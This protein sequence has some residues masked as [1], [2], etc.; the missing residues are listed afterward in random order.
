MGPFESTSPFILLI[1]LGIVAFIIILGRKSF[2]KSLKTKMLKL[3]TGEERLGEMFAK[4]R[5]LNFRGFLLSEY[6]R[7]GKIVL[8]TK[9]LIYCTYDEK[10]VALSICPDEILELKIGQ[11]GRFV[12]Y[13]SLKLRYKITG[14][15]KV[16]TW[17]IP[18]KKVVDGNPLIFMQAKTYKNPHTPE[19][20]GALLKVWGEKANRK[21][22]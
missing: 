21:D 10:K 12:K 9:R 13:P 4:T 22:I 2:E 17:T 1:A 20:F 14:K 3:E 7:E 18:E 11:S 5:D 19:S 16:V 15:D 8:T 6:G